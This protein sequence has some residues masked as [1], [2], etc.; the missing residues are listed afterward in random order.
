VID[1]FV[2]VELARACADHAAR[3]DRDGALTPA[4]LGRRRLRRRDLRGD[5][6]GWLAEL[7][8]PGPLEAL[9]PAFEALR[10]ELDARAW[11]G[12]RRFEIQVASYPGDGARYARHLDAF[13]GDPSRRVTAIVYLNPAWTKAHGGHLVAHLPQGPRR[14]EP[15][16]DRLVVFLSD[17]VP[18]EVEPTHAPRFAATAWYRGAEPIPLL[19]DGPP[20][21]TR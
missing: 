18:H 6:T 2:G 9:G 7:D 17:R 13:A 4:T 3:L 16:L 14:I 10:V 8:D 5:R 11:L 21:A 12:L 20:R 19:P 1:G 15:R